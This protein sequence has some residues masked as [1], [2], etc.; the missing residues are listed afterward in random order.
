MRIAKEVS[1]QS[2]CL[3][4]KIGSVLVRDNHILSSGYNGPSKSIP[5][6]EYRDN[7]GNYTNNVVELKCPRKR[8]GFARGE[9]MEHCVACHSEAN[10]V[11]Q[12][13]KL[14][15][16]TNGATLF[17]FCG[18][19]CLC[20]TKELINAGIKRVVCLGKAGSEYSP[21]SITDYNFPIAEKLYELAGVQVD[22]IEE[23]EI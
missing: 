23:R 11:I 10:S 8:M 16:M 4:R 3:S 9:G 20:C 6:C 13:A 12:A 15:I 18:L 19:P 22:V 17:C 21:T 14:G 1:T 7:K 5:H 2:K